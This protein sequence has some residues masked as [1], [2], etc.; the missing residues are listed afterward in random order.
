MDFFVPAHIW[1]SAIWKSGWTK[2][3]MM[4]QI[5][6]LTSTSST[7]L[8]NCWW[9]ETNSAQFLTRKKQP[10]FW[11]LV[12]TVPIFLPSDQL[13]KKEW[14]SC[15]ATNG[16]DPAII[17]RA[18]ELAALASRGENLVAACAKLSK[19]EKATLENAVGIIIRG[20][21][22]VW[23]G[24]RLTITVSGSD[25]SKVS[26]DGLHQCRWNWFSGYQARAGTV[27]LLWD[28]QFYWSLSDRLSLSRSI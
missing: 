4:M 5:K 3:L 15:A 21:P 17:A 22:L 9:F 14:P 28:R 24:L 23:L 20:W 2:M 6:W 1:L 27:A 26:R 18:N 8:A 11:N 13:A 12:W 7:K 16:I 25:C 19:T 10:E